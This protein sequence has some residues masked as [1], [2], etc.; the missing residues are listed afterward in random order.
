MPKC[1]MKNNIGYIQT[2]NPLMRT[3]GACL[4]TVEGRSKIHTNLE[5]P[6]MKVMKQLMLQPLYDKSIQYA[7]NRIS[8]FSMQKGRCAITGKLF[9]NINEMECHHKTPKEHK[10]TD[11]FENLV[12]LWKPVHK[13]IHAKREETIEKYLMEVNPDK[14]QLQAINNLRI[15]TKNKEIIR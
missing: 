1:L 15:Q 4:Y 14:K 6:N 5:L 13:L 8:L 7:D 11:D 12:W 3:Y 2:K 10:G 9:E